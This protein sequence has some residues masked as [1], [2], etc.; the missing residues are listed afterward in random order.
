MDE[1]IQRMAS[2]GVSVLQQVTF[3]IDHTPVTYTYFDTEPQGKYVLG[4]VLLAQRS[5]Q[6]SGAENRLPHRSCCSAM[7][8]RLPTSGRSLA[9]LVLG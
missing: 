3:E 7:R 5:A 4:L 8:L 1:E 9:S 6:A 2:L